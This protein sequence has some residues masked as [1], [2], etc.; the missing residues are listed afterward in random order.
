MIMSD[1]KLNSQIVK[2]VQDK[3]GVNKA[4]AEAAVRAT[5]ESI[6]R[7]AKEN[8]KVTIIGFGTF[9]VKTR[10]ARTGRNPQ[11][12]ASVQIPEKQVLAFKASK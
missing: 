5:F 8:G 12:G 9:S 7:I 1:I 11:T 10:A 6:Q 3:T 2:A 4:S